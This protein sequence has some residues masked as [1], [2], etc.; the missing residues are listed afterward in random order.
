MS[1]PSNSNQENLRSHFK[2]ADSNR[3]KLLPDP[4]S[5]EYNED[6]TALSFTF[7]AADGSEDKNLRGVSLV[8][9]DYAGYSFDDLK[10]VAKTVNNSIDTSDI[11]RTNDRARAM[12]KSLAAKKNMF[13]K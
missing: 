10:N 4:L 9:S 11:D 3:S 2:T 6:K 5:H 7:A 12:K 8:I 13:T 1:S